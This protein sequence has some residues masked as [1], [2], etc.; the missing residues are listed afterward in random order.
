MTKKFKKITAEK[1]EIFFIKNYNFPIP[2]LQKE[3]HEIS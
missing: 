3:A 1:N 2:G